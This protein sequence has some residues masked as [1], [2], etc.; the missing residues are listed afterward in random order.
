MTGVARLFEAWPTGLLGLG[1]KEAFGQKFLVYSRNLHHPFGLLVVG[2]RQSLRMGEDQR[3]PLVLDGLSASRPTAPLDVVKVIGSCPPETRSPPT[4][5]VF[6]NKTQAEP[7]HLAILAACMLLE[8]LF[9]ESA[10]TMGDIARDEVRAS[11]AIAEPILGRELPSPLI[12]DADRLRARVRA[13]FAEPEADQVFDGLFES[14]RTPLARVVLAAIQSW[15][16]A[17]RICDTAAAASPDEL[18]AEVRD[19]IAVVAAVV[20]GDH[21]RWRDDPNAERDPDQLR[22]RIV[23]RC[24]TMPRVTEDAWDSILTESDPSLLAWLGTLVS[25]DTREIH[26][27][28]ITRALLENPRLR[29]W[30]IELSR[31]P[32]NLGAVEERVRLA[33][34]R[35]G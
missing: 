13:C 16:T 29:A 25:F 9:P 32:E 33:R 5:R 31:D 24:E 1:E 11:R 34:E 6:G 18:S 3:V 27:H 23:A 19:M 26:L 17:H 8:E 14:E 20:G 4:A 15:G 22:R 35:K 21:A 10:L 7:Y 12:L 2:D 30:A 28:E